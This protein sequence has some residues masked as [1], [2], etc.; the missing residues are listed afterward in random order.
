[1]YST[2]IPLVIPKGFGIL[3]HHMGWIH[4]KEKRR[5]PR[6]PLIQ[7]GPVTDLAL[8]GELVPVDVQLKRRIANLESRIAEEP[9]TELAKKQET[10]LTRLRVLQYYRNTHQEPGFFRRLRGKAH[11]GTRSDK[12][13][14]HW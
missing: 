14:N 12:S 9:G 13:R 8:L 10:I 3:Y 5:D 1:M 7:A 6:E 11:Q 2:K 4:G